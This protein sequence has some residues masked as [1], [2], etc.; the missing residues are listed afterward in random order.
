MTKTMLAMTGALALPGLLGGCARDPAA[1]EQPK[2]EQ[3][4]PTQAAQAAQTAPAQ[5]APAAGGKSIGVP[6]C[7]EYFRQ[8]T[9]CFAH[10]AA[11]KSQLEGGIDQLRDR[12]IED[13]KDPERRERLASQCAAHTAELIKDCA[14]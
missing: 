5:A 3:A 9:L 8:A 1:T 4:A 13:A 14:N 10:N 7:D 6:A 12:L 11:K 2:D